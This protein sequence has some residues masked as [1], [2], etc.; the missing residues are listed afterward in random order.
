MMS[1]LV[2]RGEALARERQQQRLEAVAQELRSVFGA[3]AV[4]VEEAEVLVS[5][6]GL[7]KR[8]LL[9]PSLRFLDGG[10]K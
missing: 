9:D 3:A 5:G 2:H 6:R 8:W 4:Q 7:V 1:D 10:P